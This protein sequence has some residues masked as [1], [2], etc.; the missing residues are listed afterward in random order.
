MVTNS[1]A[2]GV[3]EINVSTFERIGTAKNKSVRAAQ[4]KISICIEQRPIYA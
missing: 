4:K 3:I 1:I 2:V